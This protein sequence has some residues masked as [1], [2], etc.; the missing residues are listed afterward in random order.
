M[1]RSRELRA[2][3]GRQCVLA[4]GIVAVVFGVAAGALAGPSAA[5]GAVSG[6]VAPPVGVRGALCDVPVV[7][8]ACDAVGG[9]LDAGAAVPGAVADRVIDGIATWVASGAADLISRA[10]EA[11]SS[12]TTPSLLGDEGDGRAWFL[13][14]YRLMAGLAA[15]VMAPMLLL[16][17]LQAAVTAR[18]GVL[19][20]ALVNLPIATLGTAAALTV[21]QLLLGVTDW[22]SA[23]LAATVPG[24]AADSLHGVAATLLQPAAVPGGLAVGG[25]GLALVAL[26]MAVVA[27]VVWLE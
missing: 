4:T 8:V 27:F 21:T 11:I 26:F 12:S 20:R 16:A 9:V 1:R 7:S 13:D 22:A 5:G 3:R 25:F 10:G 17:A 24:D 23:Q 19:G 6:V 2:A 14:R 15:L 18:A